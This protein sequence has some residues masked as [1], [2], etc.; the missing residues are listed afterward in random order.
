MMAARRWVAGTSHMASFIDDRRGWLLVGARG[1][2]VK[3]DRFVG[4]GIRYSIYEF[5]EP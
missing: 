4:C 3:E 2:A 1:C 5:D